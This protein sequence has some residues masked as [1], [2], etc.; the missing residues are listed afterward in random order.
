M[1]NHSPRSKLS[2][3]LMIALLALIVGCFVSFKI[4]KSDKHDLSQYHGTVLAKPREV[5]HFSLKGI[6]NKA[7]DN[8]LL[9]GK[10]TMMFFG[11]TNC[12]YVCPTTMAELGK[13]YQILEKKHAK[14][15]PQVVMITVDPKRDTLNKLG[16]YVKAFHPNFYGAKGDKMATQSLTR[17]LGVAYAKV[18][19][20][21]GD[22]ENYDIEHTGTVLLFNPQG[23][24]AAFFTAPQN[25]ENLA[26]DYILLT[27]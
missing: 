2:I 6:D 15:L 1:A 7:F 27:S 3:V 23:L 21:G 18:A 24:L 10:W 26:E 4:F 9:K 22:P 19:L 14:P 16:K 20:P 25:A 13:F 17:E 11:F 5:S 12:G 8:S